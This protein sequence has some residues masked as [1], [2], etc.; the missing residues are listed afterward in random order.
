[1]WDCR[2]DESLEDLMANVKRRAFSDTMKALLPDELIYLKINYKPGRGDDEFFGFETN[3]DIPGN[4]DV[5]YYM[6]R[7]C[8]RRFYDSTR[9]DLYYKEKDRW[10]WGT[11]TVGWYR[12]GY[13]FLSLQERNGRSMM[14]L[15]E[16][17][18]GYTVFY[19]K[20]RHTVVNPKKC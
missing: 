2:D 3:R 17:W 14:E 9:E 5:A 1:M 20:R 11:L 16:E 7:D 6:H 12:D 10:T 15:A 18:R 13:K 8:R 19:R 4:L